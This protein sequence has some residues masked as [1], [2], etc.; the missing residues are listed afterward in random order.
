M[1]YIIQWKPIGNARKKER[2]QWYYG[3]SH[4]PSIAGQ[5]FH[6]SIPRDTE[7]KNHGEKPKMS[8]Y[9]GSGIK[10]QSANSEKTQLNGVIQEFRKKEISVPFQLSTTQ[11]MESKYV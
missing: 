1:N 7:G 11:N 3:Y 4:Y 6:N 9:I 2:A 5:K 10:K 8:P